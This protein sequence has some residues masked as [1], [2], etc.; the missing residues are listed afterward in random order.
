MLHV[1]KVKHWKSIFTLLL[2][3][4]GN[5]EFKIEMDSDIDLGEISDKME[6][7]LEIFE[8]KNQVVEYIEW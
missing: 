4:C 5:I 7:N 6:C 3:L 1:Y 8:K 2:G